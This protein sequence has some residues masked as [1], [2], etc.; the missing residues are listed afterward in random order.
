MDLGL[1]GKVAVITGSSKGIG[2]ETATVLVEEGAH[3]VIA[4]RHEE[5]LIEVVKE[6]KEQTG[7]DVAYHVCDVTNEADCKAFVQKAIDKYGKLDILINNAGS[8]FAKNFED[9]SLEDWQHD[10]DLKI[11]G[12]IHMLHAAIPELKKNG[13]AI[14]NLTAVAGKNPPANTTPTSVTRAAGL[15]LTKTLSK[16]LAQYNIRVNAVCIG[17]IR[18]GQIEKRWQEEAPELTWEEYARDPKF[19]IPLGRIGDTREA[20]NVIS[21]LVSPAASYVT[22]VAVN[23]DGGKSPS[24]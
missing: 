6:I 7:K 14:L 20:A 13:G 12:A 15:A 16:D 9:V 4:S 11:F 19:D 1:Q 17:L 8:A 24:L 18:S 21:F 10:L 3:V 5:D 22:G 23:I 2:K